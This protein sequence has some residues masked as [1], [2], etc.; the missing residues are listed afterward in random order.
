MVA[1]HE[2]NLA[3]IRMNIYSHNRTYAKKCSHS[4]QITSRTNVKYNVITQKI[5]KF[6]NC[7][8]SIKLSLFPDCLLVR[9]FKGQGT[10]RN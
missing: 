6:T 2:V 8:C 1:E 9:R 5:N 4:Y 10:E 7:Y 3:I